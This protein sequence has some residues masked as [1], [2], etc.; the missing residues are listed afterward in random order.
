MTFLSC[1]SRGRRSMGTRTA[2]TA[3]RPRQWPHSKRRTRRTSL[4]RSGR[5]R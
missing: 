4:C 2:G 5:R 3:V 1:A